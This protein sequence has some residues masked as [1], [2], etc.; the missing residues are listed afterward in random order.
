MKSTTY[1]ETIVYSEETVYSESM[2]CTE[3]T[4]SLGYSQCEPQ[5]RWVKRRTI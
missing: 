2:M 4:V 1:S 3:Y 5:R